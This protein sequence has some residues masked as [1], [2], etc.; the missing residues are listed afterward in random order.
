MVDFSRPVFLPKFV[1]RVVRFVAWMALAVGTAFAQAPKRP[2]IVLVMADD[3]G[4][5]DVAFNGNPKVKTPA[6]DQL[7]K[8][9]V[10]L[11]RFYAAPVCSPTRGSAMTGRNPNRY[12]IK[13]AGQDPLPREEVTIGKV[14]QA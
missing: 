13:W 1:P 7:A 12:G 4:F 14:L 5:G 2:N 6:L 11:D 10:R 3:L 8:D 9:G